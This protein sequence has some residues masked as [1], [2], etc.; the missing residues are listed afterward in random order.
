MK[1]D[2]LSIYSNND[3]VD[4]NSNDQPK[5][6]LKNAYDSYESA[7]TNLVNVINEMLNKDGIIDS[8]D[9]QKL[10]DAFATY[11]NRLQSLKIYIN[12]A[13]DAISGKK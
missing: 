8:N 10:D 4:K 3:L 5:T 12:F 7:H 1:A 6:D 9:K 13:I 11:R 2:Y